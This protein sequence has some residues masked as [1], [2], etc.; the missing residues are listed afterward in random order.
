MDSVC[1]TNYDSS[2]DLFRVVE[3]AMINDMEML[4]YMIETSILTVSLEEAEGMKNKAN[5]K[6][7]D[8][9]IKLFENLKVNFMKG[10]DKIKII[11][12]SVKAK[13]NKFRDSKIEAAFKKYEEKFNAN[14]KVATTDKF[15]MTYNK[16]VIEFTEKDLAKAIDDC[17][18]AGKDISKNT[19]N[20][21][22]KYTELINKNRQNIFSIKG[23][24]KYGEKF[25]CCCGEKQERVKGNPFSGSFTPEKLI[26]ELK[27]GSL[28]INLQ[29][30]VTS[31]ENSFSSIQKQANDAI[32]LAKSN[33]DKISADDLA[34]ATASNAIVSGTI[35]AYA[36]AI[37]DIIRE[38]KLHL[39]ECVKIYIGVANMRTIKNEATNM[40]EL[41]PTNASLFEAELLAE[42]LEF[43]M[44]GGI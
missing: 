25:C 20:L 13:M 31:M 29:K 16:R 37:N 39:S 9:V 30:L 33:P 17:T 15:K 7:L 6:R 1:L 40:I 34:I 10:L 36:H 4:S 14:K 18:A 19:I 41:V 2:A 44:E 21:A 22:R 27:T 26:K 42:D 24:S 35:K 38:E 11:C 23:L 32:K 28:D 8:A 12:A 5:N 3:E 43:M